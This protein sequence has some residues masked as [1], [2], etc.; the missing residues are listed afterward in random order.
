MGHTISAALAVPLHTQLRNVLVHEITSG[1][2]QADTRIPSE[3]ELCDRYGVSRTT[4]R[5]TLSELVH[6]GLLYTVQ[7]KGTYISHNALQQEL[8]PFTGFRDDLTRQGIEVSSRVLRADNL[9]ASDSLA[10]ALSLLPQSPVFRLDR[11]RVA[12][13]WPVAIQT[14][15]LPE[16]LCPDLLRF[17]FADRS[18]YEV[19]R[20]EYHLRLAFGRTMIKA[21]LATTRE[22]ELLEL[23]SLGV[24]LRTFQTTYLDDGRTIEYCE[25]I[26]RGDMYELISTAWEDRVSSPGSQ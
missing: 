22:R 18:L 8:K 17:D 4:T 7:G 16:H 3:R 19:L 23:D 9:K 20:E 11:L 12:S 14:A 1:Q 25:S 13:G 26:F 21:E 24:V 6:E 2:L 5:R 10:S 15:H